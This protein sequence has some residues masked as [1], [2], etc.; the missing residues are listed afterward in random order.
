MKVTS[1]TTEE[2]ETIAMTL[3]GFIASEELR[4]ERFSNLTGMTL[5]DLK[6]GANKPEFLGF[7]MEYALQDESLIL[8]FAAMENMNPQTLIIARHALPG[9]SHDF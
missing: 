8:E 6:N 4:Y 9:A 2:A 5:Q 1:L 3:I 7:V